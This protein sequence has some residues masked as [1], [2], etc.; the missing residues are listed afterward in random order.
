MNNKSV[1]DNPKRLTALLKEKIAYDEYKSDDY[2]VLHGT[3][4][5]VARLNRVEILRYRLE[6]EEKR[7]VSMFFKFIESGETTIET[8]AKC[9]GMTVEKFKNRLQEIKNEKECA[10]TNNNDSVSAN[11]K[12]LSESKRKAMFMHYIDDGY[13]IPTVAAYFYKSIES[14]EQ[15]T[16]L[17]SDVSQLEYDIINDLL[18]FRRD[19]KKEDII[20]VIT[21]LINEGILSVSE[22]A[23]RMKMNLEDFLNETG[24]NEKCS[25]DGDLMIRTSIDRIIDKCMNCIVPNVNTTDIGL[26]CYLLDN[27]VYDLYDW[28]DDHL[29]KTPE[30]ESKRRLGIEF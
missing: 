13:S 25:S 10:E 4:E 17:K 20:A 23:D 3:L 22:A 9:S 7:Q 26:F 27:G 2:S 18:E 11:Y 16:G 12:P 19:V 24:L 29:E 30:D 15:I 21:D 8:A 1:I 5:N 28:L 6:T 14:F